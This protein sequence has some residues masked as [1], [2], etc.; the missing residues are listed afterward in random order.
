M[1]AVR[2]GFVGAGNWAV[3]RA[4]RFVA[5]EG[6]R[7]TLGWSRS[8][9]SRERFRREIGAPTVEDWRKV[10]ESDQV[11]AVLVSTPH[12]FHYEQV[13]EALS[14]GKHVMVEVPLSLHYAQG[15]ELAEL[16]AGRNLVIYH[17][18]PF[19]SHPDYDL[20]TENLRSAGSLLYAEKTGSFEG[21]PERPWYRDLELS[22]GAFS[23]MPFEAIEFFEA[24]GDAAEVDGRQVCRGKLDVATM[25]VR[26][27]GGGEAKITF[28]TGEEVPGVSAGLVIGTNGAVQWGQGLPKRLIK[29]GEVIELPKPRDVDNVLHQ[30]EVFVEMIR[31]QRDFRAELELDLRILKAVSE[32]RE[33][34]QTRDARLGK[35]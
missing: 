29:R 2:I 1:E 20:E 17:S 23:Y 9:K 3:N 30:C 19:R 16:A 27:A 6:A 26:F 21:G 22:G 24:F 25:W 4:T 18:P 12:V 14:N 28:W 13:R 5:I 32:A 7:V 10:C 33:K 8:D 34:A 11:D 31:G 35:S 15:R